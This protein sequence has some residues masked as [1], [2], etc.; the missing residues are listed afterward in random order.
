MGTEVGRIEKEFVFKS[1]VDD[2]VPCDVH[3]S[4]KEFS[5]RFSGVS[6]DRLE[7]SPVEGKLDGL[8]IGEEVRVFFYL[9]NNYHTFASRVLETSPDHVV[10]QQPPGVY[11]NLQRKYER[12]KQEGSIDVSFSLHGTKV[13][14]NFPKSDRFSPVEPPEED[15]TFDPRRIQEVVKTFRI[16]METL[17]SDNKIVMLRD[18][19][20]RSWEE[21][22]IV[23]LGKS[24]WIP[25]TAED[26]PVRD[27]FPDER[28][29][30]KSELI[31]LEEE[32]GSA[33]YL[34]TSKLGNLL[35]EKTKKDIVSEL[36]CPVLYNEY[37]VGYVHV[38]NTAARRERISR[39]L[40]EFVQQFAKVLCY[41][42]V[43]NGYFKVENST[44]RRYEAPIIDLSASGL[45]FAHT[46]TELVKELLV[47][48]D[49]DLTVRLD[50]RTIP[51]GGRIMRK[52]RDAENTYFGLLFLKIEQAD[53]QFLFHFLYG[54]E[55][56][57]S[58][59]GTWEG[60]APP[61]PLDMS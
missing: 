57:P 37:V 27:P 50:T 41:S 14:L 28:V 9:K 16:K 56:D 51:V 30:T 11:K 55:F 5:C 39:D 40:I 32:A 18:R 3:A 24:L 52:F 2:K 12:V 44:E 4:R 29:I 13:E 49:L 25:S 26:F 36:W 17:T 43:T 61:P 34:V 35:Y 42:L 58:L 23:R 48:T 1:L 47:H 38:W 10:V 31:A 54:K 59:E 60:G 53:F 45:L 19:M 22:I 6:E 33:P 46:S 15:V 8:T 7:M 20:P 21:K